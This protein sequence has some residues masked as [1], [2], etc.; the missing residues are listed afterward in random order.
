[1]RSH[2]VVWTA[3]G[4]VEHEEF[5]VEPP[6]N[7]QVLIEVE[8]SQISPGT[9]RGWLMGYEPIPFR[10]EQGSV[11]PMRPGYC[12]AGRIR[13]VGPDVTGYRPGDPV[14][15]IARHAA[16]VVVGVDLVTAV[17]DTVDLQS[18]VFFHLA[19]VSYN[20]VRRA[21]IEFG[22]PALVLGLGLVGLLAVQAARLM[23]AVPL[24]GADLD[25]SRMRLGEQMG[26]DRVV[27]AGDPEQMAALKAEFGG[28]PVVIEAT[29]A[30]QPIRTALDLVG[31]LG[32][33]VL[34]SSRIGEIEVDL[35]RNVHMKGST[36]IGAQTMARP[37]VD[38]RRGSWTWQD[39]AR[40]FFDALRYGR[41][42]VA[43]LIT[44]RA[45]GEDA[46]DLYKL[47]G[48]AEP[49]LVGTVLTWNDATS[50]SDAA[51]A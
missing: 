42:E 31:R 12:V 48:K 26:A 11:Y 43:S 6:G 39:D 51:G 13:D 44:H 34:L 35:M 9:E 15:A 3:V 4:E 16:H 25:R 14:V 30:V 46:A 1:V 38:S 21:E 50:R 8:Y 18:A 49:S 19:F 17:P 45:R 22:E 23:G 5:E 28:F 47:V 37:R 20:G 2:G 27:D 7:G 41:A 32:R 40:A 36:V 33:V 10:N 29:A 24:I